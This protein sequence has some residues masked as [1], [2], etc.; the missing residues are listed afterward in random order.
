M[1]KKIAQDFFW[2]FFM[3]FFG[4]CMILSYGFKKADVSRK[5]TYRANATEAGRVHLWLWA[6][7][8]G[9]ASHSLYATRSRVSL[10]VSNDWLL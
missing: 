3:G 9:Y 7:Q 2:D 5:L 1:V 8:V 6:W 10:Q 4:D